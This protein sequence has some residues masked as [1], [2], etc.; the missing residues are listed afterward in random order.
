MNDTN[1]NN[2]F[3]KACR[4]EAVDRTPVW[5]MRQAGRYM[6]EYRRMRERYGILDI[7]KTP[8]LACEVTMQP[9]QTFDLD[10]GI[11]FSDI[12]PPLE[13]MGLDLEYAHG[14]GPVIH[15]PVREMLDVERLLVR[16]AEESM[17]FTLEAIRLVKRE[18]D[19]TGVP[20][21]GFSGA[22]FT[23]ACYAI[24]GGGSRAF[25]RTKRMMSAE[26]DAWRLLMQ[27]MT[28]VVKDYLLAQVSAGAQAL[29]L[30]DTWV[31]ELCPREFEDKVMPYLK[32]VIEAVRP[33]GVPLIY[34]G[35]N[36]SGMLDLIR[37]L[38]TEVVGVDW[39]I[40]LAEAWRRLGFDVAIQ[41]NL[42]PAALFNPWDKLAR[43]AGVVLDEAA[44]RPGHMFN[45]GHGILPKT[46]V[47]NVKRLVDFVHERGAKN[48][49]NR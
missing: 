18:L 28:D 17:A 10:A 30:F 20:L 32:I 8:E 31:G 22:P 21:I 40:G 45:L 13:G 47:D 34:F 15:S 16:P 9:L 1:K 36:T 37:E 5:L 23:L 35:I 46:P 24:E 26:E 27:K 7:I 4:R 44:G 6:P 33:T 39:R 41:G 2:R 42:D 49:E 19:G 14:E 48:S 25:L 43:K 11:I 29:Q 38:K 12:L 3:L